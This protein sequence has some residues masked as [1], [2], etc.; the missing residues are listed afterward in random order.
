MAS[1]SKVKTRGVFPYQYTATENGSAV[2][3]QSPL[4]GTEGMGFDPFLDESGNAWVR[5]A[6]IALMGGSV[7]T[8]ENYSSSRPLAVD[9]LG[10]LRFALPSLTAQTAPQNS[11]STAYEASRQVKASPGVL[12]GLSGYNSKTSTQF[13]LIVDSGSPSVPI[14]GVIPVVVI[15]VSAASN[16]SYDPGPAGRAFSAGIWVVNSSTGP[17]VTV[18]S[19]DCFFDAQYV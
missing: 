1:Q 11:T 12:L 14:T 10:N 3:R 5:L 13:I 15:A 9:D 2:V 6:R 19:A 18:G 16:F 4:P 7:D 8:S 17:T